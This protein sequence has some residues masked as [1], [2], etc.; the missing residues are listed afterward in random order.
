MRN[1][2]WPIGG[3][4]RN[5]DRGPSLSGTED[6]TGMISTWQVWRED[7][8]QGCVIMGGVIGEFVRGFMMC[9]A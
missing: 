7:G 2:G 3:G 4:S 9:L 6:V 5:G 1:V 8:L